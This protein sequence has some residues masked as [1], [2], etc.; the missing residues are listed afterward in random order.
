MKG[1]SSLEN[2]PSKR[3]PVVFFYRRRGTRPA[4]EEGH[5]LTEG[6]SELSPISSSWKETLEHLPTSTPAARMLPDRRDQGP[7]RGA[8][9]S[10]KA[11]LLQHVPPPH[12]HKVK[13]KQT[14]NDFQRDRCRVQ[15]HTGRYQDLG[16]EHDRR[17]PLKPRLKLRLPLGFPTPETIVYMENS[18]FRPNEGTELKRARLAPERLQQGALLSRAFLRH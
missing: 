14:K 11:F 13:E 6:E 18:I 4:D 8:W 10:N 1:F 15:G 9:A 5:T 7:P 3:Q 12:T 17:L 2:A 16:W